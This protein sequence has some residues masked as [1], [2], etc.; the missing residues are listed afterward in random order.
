MKASISLGVEAGYCVVAGQ[1]AYRY[2][3]MSP[4]Q[5]RLEPTVVA[6]DP[7]TQQCHRLS[8]FVGDFLRS[9][10]YQRQPGGGPTEKPPKEISRSRRV[11]ETQE[12]C[13][14][15]RR[16]RDVAAALARP[17]RSS[18]R[19]DG[20]VNMRSTANTPSSVS[21]RHG[22]GTSS[23]G[24]TISGTTSTRSESWLNRDVDATITR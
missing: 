15:A 24:D 4:S 18:S 19:S 10:T 9:A 12:I 23:G 20:T 17:A 8:N 11:A 6:L 3:L 13:R 21:I 1:A 7:S 22:N 5:P 16:M 14:I 2:S